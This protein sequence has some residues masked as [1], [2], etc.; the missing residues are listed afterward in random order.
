MAK[1]EKLFKNGRNAKQKGGFS[2][3][4]A[5]MQHSQAFQAL[6]ASALRVL[7]W[8]LFKNFKSASSEEKFVSRPVFKFTHGEAKKEL[9]MHSQTFSRAKQE[10]ADKGFIRWVKRGGL[11][12]CNGVASEFALSSD[13]ENWVDSSSKKRQ[14]P[15]PHG[16]N[17]KSVTPTRQVEKEKQSS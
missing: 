12:G 10:L 13:W 1:K 5:E 16:K 2:R 6:T 15:K 14:P 4:T 11:K 7:L 17:L 9:G 8:C 3:V